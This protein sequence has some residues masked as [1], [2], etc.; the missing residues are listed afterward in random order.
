MLIKPF[1]AFEHLGRKCVINVDNM[2]ANIV[3]EAT[4]IAL[5]DVDDKMK[6]LSELRNNEELEK[7]EL[8]SNE[9]SLLKKS[10]EYIPVS[11]LALFVTQSCNLRCVYCYGDGGGYGGS[12]DMS[13]EVAMKAIDWLIEQSGKVKSLNIAFFGG[14]PL[15]NFPLMKQIVE[16]ASKRGTETDKKFTYSIT[17]N[18]T[19]L[20]EEKIAFLKENKVSVL[21]SFDGSEEIQN[22]QRP[23]ADG[24]PSYKSTIP[25]IKKLLENFP[26][27]P[28]RATLLEGI[29][30]LIVKN[31]LKEIGFSSIVVTPASVSLFDKKNGKTHPSRNLKD[32]QSMIEKESEEWILHTKNRDTEK[33]KKISSSGMLTPSMTAFLN[34][35][36][37]YHPCGAGLGMAAVSCAG[38]I[39]LCHRFVG[40]D[41]YKMGTVF[42]KG[43]KRDDY[44]KSPTECIEKCSKCFAKYFC[45]GGCKHDNA[46]SCSS[47]FSPPEDMCSLTC[48]VVELAAYTSSILDS[49]DRA[50]LVE[51]KIIPQKP[52]PFDF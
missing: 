44:L 21:I 19:L 17:T 4:A 27:T 49:E 25:K 11:N 23:F 43:L 6:A 7:L 41:E 51:N 45:A 14:E 28:C 24:S 5:K 50:F 13:P 16:Y 32:V 35:E 47:I 12:G 15:M 30:P 40:S 39:F 37:K 34:N 52:C 33:L 10:D 2:T 46:G 26:E 38:D 42:E 1:H 3:G 22:K 8:F 31:A 9:S 48:R 29:D 18:A 36:K 20:D